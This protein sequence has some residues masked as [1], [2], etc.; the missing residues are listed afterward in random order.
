MTSCNNKSESIQ[1]KAYFKNV[2]CL[3]AVKLKK[4]CIFLSFI[5]IDLGH[6]IGSSF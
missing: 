2:Y 3:A 6:L 1:V 4:W 5:L